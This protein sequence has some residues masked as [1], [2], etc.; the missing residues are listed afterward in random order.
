MKIILIS[1]GVLLGTIAAQ[2]LTFHTIAHDDLQIIVIRELE[3]AKGLNSDTILF[4]Y[5][6]GL[7]G[8]QKDDLKF[9]GLDLDA[10]EAFLQIQKKFTAN[11]VVK[12]KEYEK[13][14]DAIIE[15]AV[16]HNREQIHEIIDSRTNNN[17]LNI[18]AYEG[19]KYTVTVNKTWCVKEFDLL[20]SKEDRYLWVL[21]CWVKV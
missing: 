10:E 21:L 2:Y 9:Y 5:G 6:E 18:Y 4:E 11:K 16:R 7:C 8:S 3:T 1:I 13:E 12:R 17:G 14:T 20:S 15:N 19:G